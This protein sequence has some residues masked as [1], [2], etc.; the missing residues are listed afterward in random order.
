MEAIWPDDRLDT[1]RV[2]AKSEVLYGYTRFQDGDVLLPK[3]TPTFEAGRSVL[4]SKLRNGVGAGTTELH[5]LRPTTEVEARYL[6]YVTKSDPFLRLGEGSMYGV[7]GQKRVDEEFVR[8]FVINVPKLEVQRSIADRLDAEASLIGAAKKARLRQVALLGERVFSHLSAVLTPKLS[9]RDGLPKSSSGAQL[10]PLRRVSTIQSGVTIDASRALAG[11]LVT[12]PYLR[13]AN[14]QSGHLVLDS[15]AEVTLPRLVAQRYKLQIGDVLMTE[16]GDLDKLGRGA[17]WKGQVADCLHQNHVFAVRPN[18]AVLD[19]D[20]LALL[21]RTAYARHYFEITGTKTTNLASTSSSKILDFAVPLPSIRWQREIVRELHMQMDQL[22]QLRT[23]F[24]RQVVL[25][26]EGFRA[27][28]TA[29][30][31]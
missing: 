20:Y 4:I 25:L 28:V 24:R 12:R 6:S 31:K 17:V 16:G 23:A 27:L 10:V 14:V 13:V 1:R 22:E 7:A 3:I 9:L 2:K 18:A 8:N 30:V 26:D 11:E 21:T 29:L 15:L 19:A 5:V